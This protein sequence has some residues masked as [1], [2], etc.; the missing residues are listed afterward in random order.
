MGEGADGAK[1][2]SGSGVGDGVED[3]ARAAGCVKSGGKMVESAD[4]AQIG[5]PLVSVLHDG[6]A[7][8]EEANGGEDEK[9]GADEVL[10]FFGEGGVEDDGCDELPEAE[11]GDGIV[12]ERREGDREGDEGEHGPEKKGSVGDE[13]FAEI[14]ERKK[15]EAKSCDIGWIEEDFFVEPLGEV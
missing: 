9:N 1:D 7:R 3:P 4:E 14:E 15:E 5:C 11:I 8:F 2:G 10:P 13:R 6:N 12:G